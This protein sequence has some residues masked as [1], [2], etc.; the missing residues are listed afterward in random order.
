MNSIMHRSIASYCYIFDCLSSFIADHVQ[1]SLYK[2]LIFTLLFLPH[3]NH[4]IL[5]RLDLFKLGTR[6][7]YIIHEVHITMP[8]A[9]FDQVEAMK[10]ILK[11]RLEQGSVPLHLAVEVPGYLNEGLFVYHKVTRDIIPIANQIAHTY[12]GISAENIEFRSASGVAID[13]LESDESLLKEDSLMHYTQITGNQRWVIDTIT[14]RDLVKELHTLK[15][16]MQQL[17]HSYRDQADL[18]KILTEKYTSIL[19]QHEPPLYALFTKN[20]LKAD[21]SILKTA[22]KLKSKNKD[23]LATCIGKLFSELFDI[24]CLEILYKNDDHDKALIVGGLHAA[25]VDSVL[26]QLGTPCLISYNPGYL[27]QEHLSALADYR[28]ARLPDPA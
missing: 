21:M 3:I 7:V 4:A 2:N 18:A 26:K 25:W 1:S 17:I 22:R 11:F 9:D 12:S 10:S 8:G 6:Y 27:T 15:E 20:K 28:S 19:T 14:F 5:V 23:E 16:Q 13:I 24:H